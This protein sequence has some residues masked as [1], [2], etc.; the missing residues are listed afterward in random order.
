MAVVSKGNILLPNMEEVIDYEEAPFITGDVYQE[1]IEQLLKR[2]KGMFS[3]LVLYGDREHFSNIEFLT[4]YDPRFEEALLLLSEN[5]KPMLIVGDEGCDYAAR[6]PF[7]LDVVVYPPFSLPSQPR[8]TQ[9]RLE[10]ILRKAGI[11]AQSKLGITGWKLF[12]QEDSPHFTQMYDLPHFI[13]NPIEAVC[14]QMENVN[15]LLIGPG[16]LR[17]SLDERELILAEISGTKASRATYRV[18][19]SLKPGISELEASANLLIDGEPLSVHANIN[20]GQ[21]YFYALASPTPQTKLKNGDIVGAGMAYR[22]SL[23]HKVSFYT[24]DLSARPKGAEKHYRQYFQG[25]TSWYEAIRIG[26]TGGQV[27]DRVEESV[28]DLRAFGIALNPG[29]L[30]HTEEWTSSPFTKGSGWKLESGM[31]IQCDFTAA[32]PDLGISAHSEDGLMLAD[33]HL[34]QKLA[35]LAPKAYQ[36]MRNRQQ[37]MREVLGIQIADEVLPVSDMPGVVFPTFADLTTALVNEKA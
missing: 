2:A 33:A 32:K 25:M 1:R 29:H 30:I 23:C 17:I 12:T 14:S 37:F 18:L 5:Q 9:L 26:A 15:H 3:H 16:G 7:D 10:D 34:Q 21:N 19:K 27:Y 24:D 6:I 4:G 36:R 20:F 13:M 28:G 11:C 35:A 31:L 22:R 8:D